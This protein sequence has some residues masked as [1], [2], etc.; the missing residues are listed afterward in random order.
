MTAQKGESV[1]L[2]I[3]NGATPTE[4]FS[5][6]G[7]L[8]DV[9]LRLNNK[10]IE[11]N[12]LVSGRYRSL[13]SQSGISYIAVSGK[14]YFT[15]SSAEEILKGY[16]FSAT[17]NNYEM[18][19]GNGDKISGKFVISNYERSGNLGSQEDFALNLESAGAILFTIGT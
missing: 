13:I 8:R 11:S 10:A 14:G 4:I 17:A 3:G 1:I 5:E 12:N 2:K 16:A 9:S 19:F 7:G 18:Y 15:D 6:T